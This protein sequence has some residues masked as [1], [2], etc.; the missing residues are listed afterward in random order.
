MD[1]LWEDWED[2]DG[3]IHRGLIDKEYSAE[4]APLY[5]NAITDKLHLIQPTKHKSEM[6]KALIEMVDMNLIEWPSEY[7]NRGYI[8]LVYDVDTKTG[9]KTIRYTDP[10]EKEV[11]ELLRAGIEV[12]RE[13]YHLTADEEIAL[14]QIDA[15]KTEIVNIYRFKQTSGA[16]R[17]DLAPDKVGKLNDDRSYV[18]AM[19]AWVLQQ[20][21]RET[22]VT[23][24]KS[25]PD[26][27]LSKLEVQAG[28]HTEK[29]FG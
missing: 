22:L 17:F 10:T 11:K 21:R 24:K 2:D 8:N 5:P 27:I 3:N 7:D 18:A 1:F 14:K 28:K 26:E 9:K 13:P 4:E 20:L 12:V 15:T 16:D 23:R 6:Y 19:S 25:N 29:L